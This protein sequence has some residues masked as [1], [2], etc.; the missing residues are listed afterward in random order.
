MDVSS[1]RKEK[2]AKRLGGCFVNV[3]FIDRYFIADRSIG[4]YAFI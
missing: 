3:P 2:M 1:Y 4:K